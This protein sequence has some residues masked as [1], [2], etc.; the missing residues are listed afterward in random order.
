[1]NRNAVV[2]TSNS[3]KPKNAGTS[4]PPC[5]ALPIKSSV[6]VQL[7]K[8]ASPS[9]SSDGESLTTYAGERLYAKL[10][11]GL[12][13]I[14]SDKFSVN[15]QTLKAT[16]GNADVVMMRDAICIV[17]NQDYGVP[18]SQLNWYF[19]RTAAWHFT[20]GYRVKMRL[21]R[22]STSLVWKSILAAFRFEI[23]D[24]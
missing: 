22:K 21:A 16:G 7:R 19:Q 11:D 17:A 18:K 6:K 20:I 13:K 4:E 23:K 10:L 14:S 3:A 8:K 12:C 24:P 5:S 1:M 2:K 9:K 15:R